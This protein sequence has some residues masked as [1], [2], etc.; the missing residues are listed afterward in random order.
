M[1]IADEGMALRAAAHIERWG[2]T[3]YLLRDDVARECKAAILDHTPRSRGLAM[4]GAE[5]MLIAAPL[6]IEPDYEV[7]RIVFQ[8]SIYQLVAPVKGPRPAGVAIY[9]DADVV[10]ESAFDITPYI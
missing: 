4:E 6:D 1:S 3:A 10:Y 7:D 2:V 9:F 5:R 8:G